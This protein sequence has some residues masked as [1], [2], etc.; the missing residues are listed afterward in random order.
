[1]RDHEYGM[2][3][4]YKYYNSNFQ[5]YGYSEQSLGWV[6]GKQN[7]RFAQLTKNLSLSD[8]MKIMDV[9]CGFGDFN[10]WMEVLGY[11]NYIYKGID[12]IEDF[13]VTA[14]ELYK[15]M[16]NFSFECCNFLEAQVEDSYDYVIGSGIFNLKMKGGDNYENMRNILRKAFDICKEDGALSFDFLSDKVDY[17]SNGLA[18]HNTPEKVLE[19]AYELSRNI[20]LDNSYMPFE[21][22]ITIF[23][24]DS[25]SKE[26]TTFE[27]FMAENIQKYQLGIY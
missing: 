6:K 25:Y 9:G 13:I 2:D 26:N 24:N 18:F 15:D 14:K 10:K 22:S 23:K 1:M 27:K 12:I 20:I 11:K 21:F 3:I 16:E 17:I 8:E 19:I 7:I 4:A 5:K